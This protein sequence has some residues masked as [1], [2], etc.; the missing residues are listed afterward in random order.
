M[1]AA[2]TWFA[3]SA[4]AR[5]ST[6]A[7]N[8]IE[9]KVMQFALSFEPWPDYTSVQTSFDVAIVNGEVGDFSRCCIVV[10]DSA[11]GL[12]LK[13]V[14]GQQQN[15]WYVISTFSISI[16]FLSLRKLPHLSVSFAFW[17]G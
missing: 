13:A 11:A 17:S 4:D 6:K 14:G 5:K 3:G 16:G 15:L 12:S 9:P 8:I 2:P 7:P 1:A 10:R